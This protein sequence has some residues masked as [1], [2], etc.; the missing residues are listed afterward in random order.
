MERISLTSTGPEFSRIA[1]GMWRLNTWN[2]NTDQLV[3][4]L[5]EAIEMGFTTFDHA[6]IYGDYT[7]EE[8]FGRA[9]KEKPELRQKME[10]VSKCGIKLISETRPKNRFHGYDTSK[11]HILA[12]VETSLKNL[13][14]NHL[15]LLLI[16]R[17]DPLMN[18]ARV[19]EAF[20]ELRENGKVRYFGV[21][22]FTPFQF[23]LLQSHLHFQLVTNQVEVSVLQMNALHDGTLD[24]C[25]KIDIRPMAWSPFG[26][27]TLFSGESEREKALRTVLGE[28]ASEHHAAIDQVALAWLLKHPAGIIPV[29]GTGNLHRIRGA[30]GA[31]EL[32]LSRDEWFRIWTA[33]AGQE[34]P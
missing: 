7:C 2:L 20:D 6:D 17:P 26:G 34:V 29:L 22:N 30:A 16:H 24:Q 23:E 15:D 19:A 9:L 3:G 27:G 8:I 28:I 33:S 32:E 18:A 21:S 25:Q 12:S 31:L 5:E 4:F 14:T 13:H 10:L 1:L 11:E